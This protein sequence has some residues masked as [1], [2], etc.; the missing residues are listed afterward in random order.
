MCAGL[1]RTILLTGLMNRWPGSLGLTGLMNW[2]LK[3]YTLLN[4]IFE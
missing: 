3:F 1:Q 2:R 4:V